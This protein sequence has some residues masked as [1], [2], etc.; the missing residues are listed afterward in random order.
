[1]MKRGLLY[2]TILAA[3]IYPASSSAQ[4][5]QAVSF[6]NVAFTSPS[7]SGPQFHA[8]GTSQREGVGSV[9]A[10][11]LNWIVASDR[12]IPDGNG[13]YALRLFENSTGIGYGITPLSYIVDSNGSQMYAASNPALTSDGSFLFLSWVDA[14]G[15]LHWL[16]SQTTVNSGNIIWGAVNSFQASQPFIYSPSLTTFTLNGAVQVVTS[17]I[18][19]DR[20][21][22]VGYFAAG[23]STPGGSLSNYSQFNNIGMSPG[24]GS[25]NNTIYLGYPT[26]ASNHALYYLTS[27]DGSNFSLSSA[28]SNDSSSTSPALQ[29]FHNCLYMAFRTND[30]DHK[31]IYK[32]SADGANWTNSTSLSNVRMGGPP[33]LADGTTLVSDPNKL[34]ANIVAND[35]SYYLYGGE[36]N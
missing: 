30:G 2:A 5:C 22:W 1:M 9:V 27:S 34:V 14:S 17:A 18:T 33:S 8:G 21:L 10:G 26:N 11:G 16:R 35:S 19:S 29:S 28:A 4:S 13:N 32:Y 7:I 31:F 24:L 3:S 12:T 15:I 20:T 25:Y 36:S 6:P 23:N